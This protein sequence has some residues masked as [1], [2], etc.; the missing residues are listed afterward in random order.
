MWD[1]E[2]Q[3]FSLRNR[4]RTILFPRVTHM[5]TTSSH[6]TQQNSHAHKQCC[7]SCAVQEEC[8]LLRVHGGAQW[9]TAVC[10]VEVRWCCCRGSVRPQPAVP[11]RCAAARCA[12]SPPHS[13]TSDSISEKSSQ[14]QMHQK[15]R[16]PRRQQQ[17]RWQQLFTER[18]FVREVSHPP[19]PSCDFFFGA[20]IIGQI[21]LQHVFLRLWGWTSD[22]CQNK[23]EEERR[24][25]V[26]SS[27]AKTS[28]GKMR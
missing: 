10:W 23:C 20:A 22:D 27:G 17:G 14:E 15:P 28:V 8:V 19:P 26:F 6:N 2:L 21:R 5:C 9:L 16:P 1:R 11:L 24:A 18:V 12:S 4:K 13:P 25:W 3:C 7:R